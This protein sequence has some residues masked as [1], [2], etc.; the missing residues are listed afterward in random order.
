MLVMMAGLLS[1]GNTGPESLSWKRCGPG[2][3]GGCDGGGV[4]LP[5]GGRAGDSLLRPSAIRRGGLNAS[6][7]AGRAGV[8]VRC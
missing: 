5:L 8:T 1:A 2:N 4:S 6:G 7:G 3:G